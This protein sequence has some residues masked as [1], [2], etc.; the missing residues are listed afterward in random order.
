MKCPA[1]HFDQPDAHTTCE[2]CG[3]I[4]AKYQ[5]ETLSP[6]E[7]Y[8]QERAA[9]ETPENGWTVHQWGKFR[10][11][12]SSWSMTSGDGTEKIASG[13]PNGILLSLLFLLTFL[14]FPF[15]FFSP[16]GTMP[17]YFSGI[18]L[19]LG[20]FLFFQGF[21]KLREKRSLED[22]PLS[23]LRAMAPGQVEV[24]GSAG[25][26]A[27][28]RSPLTQSPCVYYEYR[29]ERYLQQGKESQWV[30]L[31]KGDS[32]QTPFTLDDGTGKTKVWPQGA[33]TF[34]A[35]S[36]KVGSNEGKGLSGTLA[37]FMGT[38]GR[39][40]NLRGRLRFTESTFQSGQWIFAMGICRKK[41]D[42][43]G[44]MF[45]GGGKQPG[46][47]FILSDKSRESLERQFTLS[48]LGSILFALALIGGS[49]YFFLRMTGK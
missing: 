24:Q 30:T 34:F 39:S 22:I 12:S 6:S 11:A 44:E 4:F 2:C 3:L 31:E 49:V 17:Y 26:D 8:R 38:Q 42:A 1:C 37:S 13:G 23:T 14:G 5:P 47:L 27:P 18:G 10:W 20:L 29:V 33:D 7:K 21:S 35:K 15:L 9:L 28:L 16:Q 19:L 45:L 43:S 46:D 32:K 25:A 40:E 41:E 48:A 36:F